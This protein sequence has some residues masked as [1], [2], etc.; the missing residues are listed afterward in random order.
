MS[1][2]ESLRRRR[3]LVMAGVA[4]AVALGAAPAYGAPPT[5]PAPA[6]SAGTAPGSLE[7]VADITGA[8][9]AW[10]VGARGQG[11]DVALIDTGVAPVPGL[12]APGKVVNGLDLSFDSQ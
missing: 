2:S 6:L 1:A 8:R 7:G 11:V 5:A 4:A 12:D 10:S 9:A 3:W